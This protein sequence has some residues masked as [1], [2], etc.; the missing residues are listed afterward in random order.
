M[1][2]TISSRD[3]NQRTHA[4][5]IAARKGPV[6]VTDRG[7]PSHVLLTIEEY[8]RITG[9]RQS[10]ADFARSWSQEACEIDFPIERWT[11]WGREVDLT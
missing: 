2:T 4:A 10:L 9:P 1:T 6:V 5:K 7:R 11:D 3:F 8:E